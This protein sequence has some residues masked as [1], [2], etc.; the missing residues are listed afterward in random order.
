MELAVIVE[1]NPELQIEAHIV[2]DVLIGHAVRIAWLDQHPDQ[3]DRYSEQKSLAWRS[4]YET[5]SYTCADSIARAL[6]F[7]LELG[8]VNVEDEEVEVQE[9]SPT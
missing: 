3:A 8:Q 4:F 1:R 2:L 6:R 5:S 7:L 9:P